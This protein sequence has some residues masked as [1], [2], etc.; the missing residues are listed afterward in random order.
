MNNISPKSNMNTLLLSFCAGLMIFGF[1]SQSLAMEPNVQDNDS[2]GYEK[3]GTV[4]TLDTRVENPYDYPAPASIEFV[5]VNVDGNNYWENKKHTGEA[6]ANS[7]FVA[8]QKY[9][10]Q[11]VGRFYIDMIY[12][13]DGK[14][15]KEPDSTEIIVFAEDSKATLNGCGPDFQ[16]VIKPD[17]SKAVCVFDKSVET[18]SQRGWVTD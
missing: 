7:N 10:I 4:M 11:N 6:D 16:I 18:L 13:V 12:E 17:Y 8:H 15:T 3:V 5:F 9:F 2:T 1:G 14:V